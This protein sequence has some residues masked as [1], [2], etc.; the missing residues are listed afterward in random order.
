MRSMMAI[1]GVRALVGGHC[2]RERLPHRT[3]DLVDRLC[4]LLR[5]HVR[6]READDDLLLVLRAL[7]RVV[8][9]DHDRLRVHD[10]VEEGIGRDDLLQGL[11]QRDFNE[12]HRVDAVLVGAVV[13]H[14]DASRFADE[15]EDV[16]QAGLL[17]ANRLDDAVEVEERRC[18]PCPC[19]L[20]ELLRRRPRATLFDLIPELAFE[21]E[22]LPCDGSIGRV[23]LA[24]APEL[25]QSL[26]ELSPRFGESRGVDVYAGRAEIRPFVRDPVLDVL[27]I[28]LKSL[29]IL[30]DGGVP[31]T[32]SRGGVAFRVG[33]SGRAA[34]GHDGQYDEGSNGCV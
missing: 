33:A 29:A 27:G 5:V 19:G 21:I 7:L 28:L 34:S 14:V 2:R 20:T 23:V 30:L 13:R 9:D 17:E 6:Q 31:V 4:K 24:R 3:N 8:R 16:A 1:I 18:L 15:I 11:L 12:V 32:G 26:I 10:L 22:H 25:H